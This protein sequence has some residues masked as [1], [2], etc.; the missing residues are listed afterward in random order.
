MRG[1]GKFYSLR[2]AGGQDDLILYVDKRKRGKKMHYF[3]LHNDV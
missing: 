3:N 1:C 2:I